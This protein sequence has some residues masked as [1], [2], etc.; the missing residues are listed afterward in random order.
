MFTV[1]CPHCSDLIWIE[2]INCGIF[3]HGVFKHNHQQIPPHA[4][5][6]ECEHFISQN[7]IYG[8]GQPFRIRLDVNGQPIVEICDW[9]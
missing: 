5:K 3:R 2:Q 8:C 7:L 4:P 1:I 6:E 9:I